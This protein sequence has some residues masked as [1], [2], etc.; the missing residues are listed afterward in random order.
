[1]TLDCAGTPNPCHTHTGT[2]AAALV[3][4]AHTD[5][6]IR[7]TH[8]LASAQR[9]REG[10]AMHAPRSLYTIGFC[11]STISSSSNSSS[12]ASS[13]FG[14]ARRKSPKR[15]TSPSR[16]SNFLKIRTAFETSA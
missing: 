13:A 6:Y 2:A 12:R 16:S 8:M 11:G 3:Y 4:T 14:S 5:E 7:H 9:V 15:T 10:T 1:M